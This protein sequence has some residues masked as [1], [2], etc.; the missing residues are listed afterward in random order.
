MPSGPGTEGTM[1]YRY[2]LYLEDGREAGEAHYAVHIEPGETVYNG[3][4]RK[5]RVLDVIAT[6]DESDEY[7]GMLRV[8]AA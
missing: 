2:L 1:L 6:E 8:E 4:G 3:D 5:L 7:V